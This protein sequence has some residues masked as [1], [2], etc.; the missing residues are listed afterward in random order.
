M[1]PTLDKL[2]ACLD[3]L[4]KSSGL[5]DH[6]VKTR[7][8]QLRD[9]E[10]EAPS[11]KE[12][13][14]ELLA[15]SFSENNVNREVGWGTYFGPVMVWTTDSGQTLESPSISAVDKNAIDYWC[16]RVGMTSNPLLQDRYAGLV[17]DLSQR[18]IEQKPKHTYAK[19]S[20]AA[21]LK[22]ADDKLID[23]PVDGVQKLERALSLARS[24]ND[25]T[26]IAHCKSSILKY[27]QNVAED[28]KPGLW[29][30]SFDLLVDDPKVNI[31]KSVEKEIIS[32]LET[33]LESLGGGD[34]WACER[35]ADRLARYYRKRGSDENVRRVIRKLGNT[36][37]TAAE[38]ASP[39]L[40]SSWLQHMHKTY[41][42]FNLADDAERIS[43]KL[44]SIGADVVGEMKTVSSEFRIP[45][46]KLRKYV[47]EIT[48]GSLQVVAARIAME[49]LEKKDDAERLVRNLAKSAPLTYMISRQI[50][51]HEGRVV[52]TIGGVD[53][54]LDG[55]IAAQIAQNMS[56]SA[57]FLR[58]VLDKAVEKLDLT[59]ESLVS[60]LSE[61]PAYTVDQDPL[62]VR[63][64][65]FYFAN[66][67]VA[68]IHL[69][70]PQIE[71]SLRRLVELSGGAILKE[72]RGGGFNVSTLDAVLRTP[73]FHRIFGTD[74]SL[75]LRVMLTDQ[76]GWN[77]RND[78]CHGLIP[79]DHFT[80][81]VADR[82][83]HVFLLLGQL[84]LADD[85]SEEDSEKTGPATSGKPGSTQDGSHR[86]LRQTLGSIRSTLRNLYRKF[87][88]FLADVAMTMKPRR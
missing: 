41:L 20:C 34:P 43:K 1:N 61:S 46:D 48:D 30:F 55:H 72:R 14:Y 86:S 22:L 5:S 84:Q 16:L 7:L 27:E 9:D 12:F 24:L 81:T 13:D 21:I 71:A 62:L 67:Y 57:I 6:D 44:R 33:R 77:I 11:C 3:E 50:Y 2:N 74:G 53:D 78:V 60:L 87:S 75:Y 85:Q 52:A 58:E 17:W 56:I 79:A 39:M 80:R 29:G 15:F 83:I 23:P 4:E 69:A 19:D 59:A 68:F 49:F 66:D 40:A 63:S 65:G 32:D 10:S 70:I 38:N 42:R 51:D 18:A 54:D 31:E 28:G 35:A 26:L 36:F 37:E 73:E 64:F 76:R 82:L 8:L 88:R 47:D 25:E 45:E